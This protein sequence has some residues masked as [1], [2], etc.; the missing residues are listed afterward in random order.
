[1]FIPFKYHG[2]IIGTEG[3]T[4]KLIQAGSGARI[5][6]PKKD[7]GSTKV[8][9]IGEAAQVANA[10]S[11]INSLINHGY[12][13]I[14]NPGTVHDDIHVDS[15]NFGTV[16]GPKGA[17]LQAIQT[18][19]KTR[20]NFPDKDSNSERVT[21]VGKKE[22]VRTAR[23]AIKELIADG[24]SPL[25]HEGLIKKEIDFP[26]D[27]LHILVGPKGQTIKSIQGSSGTKINIPDRNTSAGVTIVGTPE[28]I[29]NAERQIN[30]ILTPPTL[31][32]EEPEEEYVNGTWA[33]TETNE[34]DLW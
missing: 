32:E 7:S 15:K 16:I 29:A 31:V 30:K 27:K 10:K 14:T 6:M 11:A 13:S 28:G 3:N 19:T 21:I 5:D 18:K 34:D 4:L 1:M 25:T 23:L 9:I 22:D 8:Q 24:F 26:N 17:Y 33:N 12:S 20:I 2:L